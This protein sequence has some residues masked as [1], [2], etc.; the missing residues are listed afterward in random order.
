MFQP[1]DTL[2]GTHEEME[3][4]SYTITYE[5]LDDITGLPVSF[6]VTLVP[7]DNFPESINIEA[8]TVYGMFSDS[9]VQSIRF[10]DTS[11]NYTIL[12]R[13]AD[14]KNV[15]EVIAFHPSRIKSKI[16]TLQAMANNETQLF[17]IEVLNDWT[18]GRNALVGLV[19]G[20]L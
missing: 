12:T 15:D 17:T 10:L 6:P 8:D 4:L 16:F 3:Q 11:G 5:Q 18:N 7:V 1:T 20:T 19:Q 9:F 2:L 13:F 14:I